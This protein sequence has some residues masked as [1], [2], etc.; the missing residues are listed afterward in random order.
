[1]FSKQIDFELVRLPENKG[2]ALVVIYTSFFFRIPFYS[3]EVFL[4]EV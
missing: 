2:F 1:M 4:R 3:E